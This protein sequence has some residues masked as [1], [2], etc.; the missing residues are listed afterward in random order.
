M[1]NDEAN[2]QEEQEEDLLAEN[3]DEMLEMLMDNSDASKMD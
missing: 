2:S 3:D 1:T